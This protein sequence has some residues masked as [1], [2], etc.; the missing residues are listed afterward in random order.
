MLQVLTDISLINMALH[1]L[2]SRLSELSIL[3]LFSW[4]ECLKQIMWEV[5]ESDQLS[6]SIGHFWVVILYN[7]EQRISLLKGN[8]YRSN[9]SMC[10]QCH[11]PWHLYPLAQQGASAH[12]A[13]PD[14]PDYKMWPSLLTCWN[15]EETP[16]E[17]PKIK[18]SYVQITNDIF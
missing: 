1:H 2:A 17:L 15:L 12:M 10:Y 16:Q 8:N 18:A 9:S 14:F 11:H 4:L 13:D 3:L 6:D 5:N 7:R